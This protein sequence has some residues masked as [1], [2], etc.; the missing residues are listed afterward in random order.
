MIYDQKVKLEIILLQ[1]ATKWWL[2]IPNS[3]PEQDKMGR[4]EEY[5]L[6][7]SPFRKLN[8]NKTGI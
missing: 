5:K 1:N 4:T 6:L 3:M 7:S 8:S 2:R